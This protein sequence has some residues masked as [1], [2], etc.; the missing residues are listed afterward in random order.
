M[1]RER[2]RILVGRVVSNKMDKTVVVSVETLKRHPLYGKV[3]RRRKRYKAH[4][5]HNACQVGDLVRMIE[6]RP[7]SKEKRWVVTEILERTSL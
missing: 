7:L 6:S 5:E 3:I 1:V 4:D 2:R